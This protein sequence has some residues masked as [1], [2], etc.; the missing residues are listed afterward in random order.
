MLYDQ[1]QLSVAYSYA[2]QATKEEKFSAIV[3]DIL[4]YVKR[5]LGHPLGAFYSAEDADSKAC[6][7]DEHKREG[8]FCVWTY[9]QLTTL[10]KKHTFQGNDKKEHSLL[11]ICEAYFKV[12]PGGNV[13]PRG[14]PHGELKNQNHLTTI[15]I[16]KIENIVAD[17]GLENEAALLSK[18]KEIQEILYAERQKRPRP[19]LD[20]KILT[21]WN[22]LM[23]SGF[24][25]SGM[26][27]LQKRPEYIEIAVQAAE[28]VRFAYT[29]GG[30]WG[31][32][33]ISKSL[34]C[35]ISAAMMS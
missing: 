29:R 28:F 31:S 30:N 20:N 21:S 4:T 17:F 25:V 8:A 6:E 24:A 3:E 23:I 1:A 22:G 32:S 7:S 33:G 12:K 14:D 2:Y 27:L 9:Q 26:A 10:L 16:D 15:G 35:L 18:V 19:H 34:L 5:D 13:D 11:E